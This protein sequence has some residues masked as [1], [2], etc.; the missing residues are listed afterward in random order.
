V[1]RS[2]SIFARENHH[3]GRRHRCLLLAATALERTVIEAQEFESFWG[4]P[5]VERRRDSGRGNI[6]ANAE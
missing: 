2:G 1:D 3:P 5:Q 6:D 4:D